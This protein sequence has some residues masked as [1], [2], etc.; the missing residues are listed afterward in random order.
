MLL[1][2]LP[3]RVRQL[4]EA[5]HEKGGIL[6]FPEGEYPLFASEE[7]IEEAHHKGFVS[8]IPSDPW[9][10]YEVVI[11]KRK[12]ARA[13]GVELPLTAWE[14]FAAKVR[15]VI[16]RNRRRDRDRH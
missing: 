14:R 6:Q 1:S 12:G 8:R 15:D 2:T 10:P 7:T 5:L 9:R 13:L 4:L 3:A 16:T 11:L